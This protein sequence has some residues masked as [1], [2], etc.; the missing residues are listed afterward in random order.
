[1]LTLQS[2]LSYYVGASYSDSFGVYT[3]EEILLG[4]TEDGEKIKDNEYIVSK[5][6]ALSKGKSLVKRGKR[7]YYVIEMI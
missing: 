2:N 3:K 7:N 1:V 6:N 5:E 4:K